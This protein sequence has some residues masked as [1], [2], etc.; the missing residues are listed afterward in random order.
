[1]EYWV[2]GYLPMNLYKGRMFENRRTLSIYVIVII[3]NHHCFE[4]D[5]GNK[6]TGLLVDCRGLG[7]AQAEFRGPGTQRASVE[8]G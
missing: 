7:T 4:N 8:T 1:M 6:K 5:Q 3:I 2:Y